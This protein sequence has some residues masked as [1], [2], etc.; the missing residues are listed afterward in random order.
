[1]GE[2]R[3]DLRKAVRV[4]EATVDS[5][6][7]EKKVLAGELRRLK[8]DLEGEETARRFAE[9]KAADELRA[10]LAAEH[11]RDAVARSAAQSESRQAAV[12]TGPS[13]EVLEAKA[14]AVLELKYAAELRRLREGTEEAAQRE[15]RLAQ[16]LQTVERERDALHQALEEKVK[17]L[18]GRFLAEVEAALAEKARTEAAAVELRGDLAD[19]L[20]EKRRLTA[21]HEIA[22]GALRQDIDAERKKTATLLAEKSEW[23]ARYNRAVDRERDLANELRVEAERLSTELGLY[24]TEHSAL[25][26]AHDQLQRAADTVGADRD[27]LSAALA[28]RE[29][30]LVLMET[31]GRSTAHRQT[32]ESSRLRREHQLEVERLNADL[33]RERDSLRVL[34]AKVLELST[35]L[36]SAEAVSAAQHSGDTQRLEELRRA[37]AS[38]EDQLVTS[39]R[40]FREAQLEV[41]KLRLELMPGK[42]G[43]EPSAQLRVLREKY[44]EVKNK[45]AFANK[46]LKE[47][48]GER[49]AP[50]ALNDTFLAEITAQQ[51]AATAVEELNAR[52]PPEEP[53]RPRL[54]QLLSL[55]CELYDA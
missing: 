29:E 13:R 34:N 23:L 22:A 53:G 5:L 37:L 10:R 21:L 25:R 54:Q 39:E 11:D 18:S 43:A 50:E 19:A 6:A 51:A 35:A 55:G 20:S 32:Q 30:R 12:P 9:L 48:L 47:L 16:R 45:L 44:A 49:R 1:M 15:Q 3:A 4:L 14:L 7:R 28:E 27:K 8:T 38:K 46:R 17:A 42:G 31:E 40:N 52:L 41:H 2:E 33:V 24:R 26:A 36:A